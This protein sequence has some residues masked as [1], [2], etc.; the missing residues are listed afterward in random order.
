MQMRRNDDYG[1]RASPAPFD[2]SGEEIRKCVIFSTAFP[3][4]A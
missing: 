4:P 3:E 1:A 2:H